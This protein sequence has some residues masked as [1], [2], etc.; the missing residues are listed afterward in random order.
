[1]TIRPFTAEEE[2]AFGLVRA[3]I[4]GKDSDNAKNR[5]YYA[6]AVYDLKPFAAPGEETWACDKWWRLYVDPDYLPGGKAGWTVADCDEALEH[7]LGHLL[8]DHASRAEMIPN[9]D[10]DRHNKAADCCINMDLPRGGF[11]NNPKSP[12]C[13]PEKFGLPDGMTT[14][15]YY[16]NLPATPQKGK[17]P[18]AA[19]GPGASQGKG[20]GQGASGAD[21]SDTDDWWDDGDGTGEGSGSGS[22]AGDGSGPMNGKCGSGAGGVPIPGELGPDD[23]PAVT[24][25][26]AEIT[27]RA[28]AN[29]VKAHEQAHGRGSVPGP[30]SAWADLVLKPPTVPWQ[31]VLGGH[32]RFAVCWVRGRV[33]FSYSRVSRRSGQQVIFPGMV[34]PV[35]KIATV[36]DESSSMSD[37]DVSEALSEVE[38]IA[39]QMGVRGDNLMM[40]T[41]TAAVASVQKVF[42][43][44][45]VKKRA[46]GGTDM[47][48]GITAAME[49]KNRPNIIVVLTDG[50]TEWPDAP[51][52]GVKLIA[53]IIGDKTGHWTANAKAKMPWAKVVR[54]GNFDD[55]DSAAAA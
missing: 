14:E 33:N 18:K 54:V 48:V 53:A 5:A 6:P 25:G 24:E 49:L 23:A 36:V 2:R 40:L 55:Q 37:A 51:L 4:L 12:F 11:I 17:K 20:H 1:M 46:H 8:R 41:V 32:L 16:A 29:G 47:R 45:N 50:D 27:R 43:I 35:P 31:R 7:E 22:E 44:R 10:H 21:P 3:H 26:Q 38:G 39:N 19:G 13:L 30:L 15:W 9:V 28:V 52:L 34:R 42:S